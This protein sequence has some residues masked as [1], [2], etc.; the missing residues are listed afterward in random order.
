MSATVPPD[1]GG[2]LDLGPGVPTWIALLG[3][4]L[5]GFLLGMLTSQA[6]SPQSEPVVAS[7]QD[8]EERV[9][10]PWSCIVTVEETYH[11]D[12]LTRTLI[13]V[14]EPCHYEEN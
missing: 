13:H 6:M 12:I 5:A 9:D 3:M 7:T 8:I 11:N 1:P 10:G 4:G 2:M 14:V